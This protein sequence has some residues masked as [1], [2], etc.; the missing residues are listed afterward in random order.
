VGRGQL[1]LGEW[2]VLG[3]PFGDGSQ[4]IAN[5]QRATRCVRHPSRDAETFGGGSVEDTIVHI[6]VD[7]DRQ[8]R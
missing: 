2:S 3:F 5:E 6:G 4:A 1:G 7:G 8:L